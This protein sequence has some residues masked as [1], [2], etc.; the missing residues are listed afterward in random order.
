MSK[1]ILAISAHPDDIE[2]A[3]GGTMFK[4]AEKGYDIYLVVATN[5]ENGFKISYKP[6]T[7][8]VR[9]RHLE[10]LKAAKILGVKNVF[11]LNYR[12]GYLTYNRPITFKTC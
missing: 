4:F 11:F 5:G 3:C 2:F 8:R 12:D 7:E 1:V 10:Q 6:R 9:I